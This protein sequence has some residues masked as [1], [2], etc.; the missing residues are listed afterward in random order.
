MSH[1]HSINSTFMNITAA[2][3]DLFHFSKRFFCNYFLKSP[4]EYRTRIKSIWKKQFQNKSFMI[5]LKVFWKLISFAGIKSVWHW[6]S[7]LRRDVHF[8]DRHVSAIS[9]KTKEKKSFSSF[10][11]LPSILTLTS[12]CATCHVVLAQ[13]LHESVC[14]FCRIINSFNGRIAVARDAGFF[15]YC[16]TERIQTV[17]LC[18]KLSLQLHYFWPLVICRVIKFK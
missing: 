15:F 8:Y 14:D 7:F 1:G 10:Q 17:N 4:S 9:I 6:K 3:Y 13:T 5:C 16:R 11:L 2:K 18:D 12:H